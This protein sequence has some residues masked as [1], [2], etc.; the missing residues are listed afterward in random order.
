[1]FLWCC[2]LQASEEGSG[3][4]ARSARSER[5]ERSNPM[6]CAA[7]RQQS[8][9]CRPVRLWAAA[10]RPGSRHPGHQQGP[11]VVAPAL[12]LPSRR[13][14]ASGD[15]HRRNFDGYIRKLIMWRD[16]EC[17]DPYCEAPIR[18]IDHIQRYADGGLT[19]CPNGRGRV[20][21]R[22]LCQRNA[23]LEGREH[24]HWIG[25]ATPYHQDHYANR[26]QLL[27]PSTVADARSSRVRHDLA[28]HCSASTDSC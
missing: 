8:Q 6:R 2:W 1:M 28:D 7:G 12:R 4:K 14:L 15:P 27:Q 10:G 18:H 25:R 26:P 22:Q 5:S 13:A 16:R 9:A 11:A 19:I 24:L 3:I 20:R 23:G 17:R 21:T